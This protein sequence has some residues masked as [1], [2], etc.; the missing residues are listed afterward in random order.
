MIDI[1]CAE[2]DR[3]VGFTRPGRSDG[4]ICGWWHAI[5]DGK[6]LSQD[7]T[8]DHAP[9]PVT[10]RVAWDWIWRPG[11]EPS[12]DISVEKIYPLYADG[13]LAICIDQHG[14]LATIERS[15]LHASVL[16]ALLSCYRGCS[17]AV[18]SDP[19]AGVRESATELMGV[20]ERALND[21]GWRKTLEGWTDEVQAP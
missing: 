3:P 9:V 6:S 17:V 16:D 2:C 14:K 4:L 7:L 15:G 1:S 5:D 19:I 20:V 10:Y 12:R 21:L 13:P 18:E 11:R 8:G